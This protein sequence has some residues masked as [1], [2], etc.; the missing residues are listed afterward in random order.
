MSGKALDRMRE[1]LNGTGAYRLTGETPADWELTACGVG[2]DLLETA[3]KELFQEL[4]FSTASPER[5]SQWEMLIRPQP[6]A[7][8]LEERR[9]MLADRMGQNP[10]GF[11]PDRLPG[12]LRGAGLDGI[13]VEEAGGLRVFYG[14]CLGLPEEEVKRELDAV[15]PAHL[16]WIWDESL[17][18][19]ALDALL[20]SF[21]ELDGKA[22]TW[23][24]LEGLTRADL[25]P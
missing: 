12:M 24:Q 25:E 11:S 22:L 9:C 13:A 16:P 10:S 17:V 23:Q 2:F 7:A 4:F 6:S 21:A 3:A 1:V 20:P 15:L 8:G 19:V 18:W 5:I 14:K